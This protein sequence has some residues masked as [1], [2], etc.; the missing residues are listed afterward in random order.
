LIFFSGFHAE[1]QP[2]TEI[3]QSTIEKPITV[4]TKTE[5]HVKEKIETAEIE[6]KEVASIIKENAEAKPERVYEETDNI[7]FSEKFD[8]TE[9]SEKVDETGFSDFCLDESKEEMET[10]TMMSTNCI[11]AESE[12]RL[13][14]DIAREEIQKQADDVKQMKEVI[15]EQEKAIQQILVSLNQHF[16]SV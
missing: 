15:S 3:F 12:S 13:L 6:E 4:E 10:P 9:F 1:N 2:E 5:E 14:I 7:E 8:D 11:D 16:L